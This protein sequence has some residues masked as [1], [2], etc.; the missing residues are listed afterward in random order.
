MINVFQGAILRVKLKNLPSRNVV[1]C[2]N[3]QNYNTLLNGS[4]SL[5][6]PKEM[7]YAKYVYHIY[8]LRAQNRDALIA[9]LGEKGVHCGIHCPVLVHLQEA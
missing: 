9:K 6:T 1:R 8:T 5:V 2:L 7:D 4:D 3:A